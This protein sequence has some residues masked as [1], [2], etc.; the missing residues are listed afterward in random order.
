MLKKSQNCEQE[1]DGMVRLSFSEKEK[2]LA[3]LRQKI[4]KLEGR[5][6]SP[7][8]PSLVSLQ[9]SLKEFVEN[10]VAR[11]GLHEIAGLAWDLE[12]A[13]L[14]AC[15]AL[16]WVAAHGKG[17]QARNVAWIASRPDLY[18]PGLLPFGLD[19]DAA[20]F[21]RTSNGKETLWALEEVLRSG[22]L[23]IAIAEVEELSLTA[24]RR[25]ALAAE[26]SGSIAFLLRRW[27]LGGTARQEDPIAAL[28]R[29]RIYPRP[30]LSNLQTSSCVQ[31]DLWRQ[32]NGPPFSWQVEFYRGEFHAISSPLV[33]SFSHGSLAAP[34]W[35]QRA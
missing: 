17:K 22:S 31:V 28:T 25:L 21:I 11:K 7:S 20:L 1:T 9:P 4:A 2:R 19:P 32:K 27:R 29:W 6:F 14:P 34:S 30:D 16:A 8:R 24:S 18:A 23:K 12:E 10:E 26:K 35:Y 33:P 5:D 15:L 13:V 3:Q